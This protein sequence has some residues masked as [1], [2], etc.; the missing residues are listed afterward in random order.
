MF[1]MNLTSEQLEFRSMLREFVNEKVK[2]PAMNSDRLQS[3][4]KPILNQL[5]TEISELGLRSLSIS[6]ELGGVG[7]DLL[8]SC[9]VL[10]EISVGDADLAITI[11]ETSL[12][13]GLFFEKFASD[14]QK[15]KYL[16]RFLEDL[17]FHLCFVGFLRYHGHF[18]QANIVQVLHLFLTFERPHLPF[19]CLHAAPPRPS[20][21]R[22]TRPDAAM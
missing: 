21:G 19:A 16:E 13:A 17:Q 6:E 2:I 18:A 22:A 3:F 10:E 14:N 12:L 1:N 7:G 11:G 9:V 15:D 5:L 20:V 4:H 8:T